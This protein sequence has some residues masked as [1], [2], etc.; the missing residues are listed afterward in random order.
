[1][2]NETKISF[3]LSF[4]SG[5]VDTAGFIALF[6]LFTAHVT[7]NLVLAGAAFTGSGGHGNLL[8]KLLMLPVFVLGVVF[9]AY[10]IKYKKANALHLIVIQAC[11]IG[12]F[13]LAGA[14]TL[15]DQINP[16]NAAVAAVAS[17]AVFGMAIQN[18]YMRKLLTIYTPNT[19]MTGNFT[20][21][22]SD[23]F[24][25]SDY[26]LFKK[27]TRDPEEIKAVLSSLK[28]VSIVLTGFLAGCFLG[29]LLVKMIGL[30]CCLLPAL[31][32]L[33]VKMQPGLIKLSKL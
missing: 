18:I 6:G 3:A 15:H 7:G 11:F 10:L 13:A 30:I 24:N 29:A 25:A 33:W 32:L 27:N 16:A 5:F 4:V 17:F 23:I 31:L 12:F 1:M 8:G 2:A 21:F 28:K 9:A 26:Y 20:Q 14:Y 22:S 19:V